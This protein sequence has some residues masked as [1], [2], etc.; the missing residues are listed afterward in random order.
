MSLADILL[1][2]LGKVIDKVVP[3]VNTQKKLKLEFKNT[4]LEQQTAVINAA[5]D[6]IVAEGS[7]ADKWTSRARP[8]FLYVMYI[9]IL[10]AI[11]MGFLS[12]FQPE[13]SA[14]VVTGF[15]G[16]LSAIPQPMWALF[17]TGYLGYV[18]ARGADKNGGLVPLIMGDKSK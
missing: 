3:D 5:R 11:P 13:L 17:G 8:S 6:T 16:W 14:L 12:A 2:P 1:G 15:Q 10:S 4:L 18:V 9:I 7:S